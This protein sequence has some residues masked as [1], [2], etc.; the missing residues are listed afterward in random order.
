MA[1]TITCSIL[2]TVYPMYCNASHRPELQTVSFPTF[3]APTNV[4]QRSNTPT[5]K[6]THGETSYESSMPSYTQETHSIKKEIKP[7]MRSFDT[8][9]N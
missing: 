3:V 4:L 5:N 8:N 1:P 7:N 9:H 2:R 6:R